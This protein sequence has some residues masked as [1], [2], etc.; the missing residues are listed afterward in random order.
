MSPRELEEKYELRARIVGTWVRNGK[1]T[2]ITHGAGKALR[3]KVREAD[4]R[5]FICSEAA[6]KHR[7]TTAELL[8]M[9]SA[10]CGNPQNRSSEA[11]PKQLVALPNKQSNAESN[12]QAESSEV[13]P[14]QQQSENSPPGLTSQS[15]TIVEEINLELIHIDP[16]CQVRAQQDKQAVAE[17]A[18]SMKGGALFPPVELFEDTDTGQFFIGDGYHRI[19]ALGELGRKTAS[20]HIHP[21][22]KSAAIRHALEANQSHGERRSSADKRRAISI[23]VKMYDK[24]SNVEIA[25]ICG[26]S[27]SSVRNHREKVAPGQKR[28]GGDG[29]TQ[30]AHKRTPSSYRRAKSAITR[31]RCTKEDAAKLIDWLTTHYKLK[32]PEAPKDAA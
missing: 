5:T 8:N 32:E 10:S 24:L 20:A 6:G 14:P 2:S 9:V 30:T 16:D 25:K 31:V 18:E 12:S 29:K 19:A 3:Y 22:G 15:K 4:F 26:V 21:G 1:L 11:T 7:K 28:I 17:Y 13:A 23:A 27:E